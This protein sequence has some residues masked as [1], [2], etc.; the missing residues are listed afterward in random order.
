MARRYT[1]EDK[2]HALQTLDDNFGDVT[3]TALADRYSAAHPPRLE[4]D[5]QA[6]AKTEGRT[7]AAKKR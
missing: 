1:E 2:Q 5:A 4:T 6:Q 3:L 7:L